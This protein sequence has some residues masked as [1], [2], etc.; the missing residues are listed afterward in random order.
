MRPRRSSGDFKSTFYLNGHLRSARTFY[1]NTFFSLRHTLK[2]YHFLLSLTYPFSPIMPRGQ[3]LLLIYSS[4]KKEFF[5]P[6]TPRNTFFSE[7]TFGHVFPCPNR[8]LSYLFFIL[9]LLFFFWPLNFW[10]KIFS[11]KTFGH[12]FPCPN[13]MLSYLFFILHL[14]FFFWP[15]DPTFYLFKAKPKKKAGWIEGVKGDTPWLRP[16]LLLSRRHLPL[17]NLTFWNFYLFTLWG[18][19]LKNRRDGKRASRRSINHPNLT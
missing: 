8:M 11:L 16:T 2:A 6:D 5:L 17:A 14:S 13:R 3:T 4:Q 18:W 1:A 19:S 10:S 12:V 7:M 9:H 15:L